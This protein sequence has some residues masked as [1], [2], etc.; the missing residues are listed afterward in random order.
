MH[1]LGPG[2]EKVHK[3]RTRAVGLEEG[4]E[5]GGMIQSWTGR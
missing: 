1:E 3:G 2:P 5:R 4:Q